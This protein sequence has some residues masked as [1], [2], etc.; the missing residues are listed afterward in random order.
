VNLVMD[1]VINSVTLT[2][3]KTYTFGPK[4]DGVRKLSEEPFVGVI[5]NLI[6]PIECEYLINKAH[7]NLKRAGVV[8]DKLNGISEGR[9][10]SNCWFRFDGD[11][12]TVRSIGQRVADLVSMPLE[13][14]ESIQI[15]YYGVGQEYRH[16]F[17][18]F[19]LGSERGNR[20]AKW[21]GQRLITVIGYLNSVNIGGGT[22]F[23]K[24]DITVNPKPGR[25]VIFHNTNGSIL[26]PHPKSL[27]AGMPVKQ[28]TNEEIRAML[29]LFEQEINKH[30]RLREGNK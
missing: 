25:A 28:M 8:L 19:K 24:L 6:S 13:N 10:G 17:D 2:H 7:G 14:A 5:E 27:H 26:G 1:K 9:T 21:G 23:S 30:K 22:N 16:H 11:D 29:K 18:A 15:I 12:E 20:A 3:S 4:Y